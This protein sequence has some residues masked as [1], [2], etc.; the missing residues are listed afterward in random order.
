MR[1]MVWIILAKF[2]FPFFS[3]SDLSSN[4]HFS[5][6]QDMAFGESCSRLSDVWPV[7]WSCATRQ[8]TPAFQ[9]RRGS[10]DFI[11]IRGV[12]GRALS[13]VSLR[14]SPSPAALSI[15]VSGATAT[16]PVPSSRKLSSPARAHALWHRVHKTIHTGLTL[17]KSL[18]TYYQNEEL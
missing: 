9:K 12:R 18:P 8:I 7:I 13:T 11:T 16:P 4:V 10:G 2:G 1:M 14:S 6:V 15:P 3:P 17:F 5:I